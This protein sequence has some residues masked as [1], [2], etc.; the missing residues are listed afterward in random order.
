MSAFSIPLFF[1]MAVSA[2]IGV[3]PVQIYLENPEKHKST[4][5]TLESINET[6]KRIFEVKVFRWTQDESGKNTLEPDQSILV[7]P[8]NFILQPNKSQ[9]IR[10]GFSKPAA[11]VLEGQQEKAWRVILDEIAPAVEESSVQFLMN[12]SLPLFIG[13]QDVPNLKFKVD[14][15]KLIVTN[16]ANS[17]AQIANLKILDSN[18]KEVFGGKELVYLLPH[19]STAFDLENVKLTDLKNYKVVFDTDK[20]ESRYK[21]IEMSLAD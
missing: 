20:V 18:K 16:Q 4:T 6:A 11:L 3:S 8:K 12:F 7:N 10:I 9:T 14:N 15:K 13:K 19:K 5:V 21:R 1:S 2:D 17:H